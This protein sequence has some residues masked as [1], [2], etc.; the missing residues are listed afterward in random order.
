MIKA[1]VSL[2]VLI[3]NKHTLMHDVL[4][5]K[6]D[7]LVIP[8]KDIDETKSIEDTVSEIFESIVDLSRVYAKYKLCDATINEDTLVLSYFCIMPFGTKTKN[9]FL[10]PSKNYENYSPNLQKI[11]RLF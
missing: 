3:F 10:L 11:I 2:Y 5:L 4:S 6:D 7:S 9:S 8:A 1:K